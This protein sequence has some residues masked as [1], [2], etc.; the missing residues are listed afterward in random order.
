MDCKECSGRGWRQGN[1]TDIRWNPCKYC[2]GRGFVGEPENDS[3]RLILANERIETLELRV[4]QLAR[5]RDEIV[6][7]VN[8]AFPELRCTTK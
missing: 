7:I 8:K 5:E 3:Q 2:K 4:E 1:E 6:Q